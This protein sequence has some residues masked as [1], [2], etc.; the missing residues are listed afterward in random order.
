ML[1]AQEV[2]NSVLFHLRFQ[3]GRSM[4]SELDCAYRSES[5]KRCA[6]GL[7]ILGTEYRPGLEG[8]SM[9]G[10]LNQMEGPTKEFLTRRLSLLGK[11][12]RLHDKKDHWTGPTFNELGEA[13]MRYLA[14]KEGLL[15]V[16]PA[17]RPRPWVQ[18]MPEQRLE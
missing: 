2:F 5:G 16:P 12:Q 18:W 7:F 4:L 14:A 3:D 1:T 6:V 13:E 17:S 8:A 15:Y 10:I 11:L 9:R